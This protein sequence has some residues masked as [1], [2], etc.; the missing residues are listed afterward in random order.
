MT[1]RDVV[2]V[3]PHAENQRVAQIPTQLPRMIGREYRR[4]VGDAR[5]TGTYRVTP[6]DLDAFIARPFCLLSVMT[7]RLSA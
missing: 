2:P 7:L 4:L 6:D 5:F 1:V 3:V